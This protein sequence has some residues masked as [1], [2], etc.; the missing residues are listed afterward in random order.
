M[1]ESYYGV[2]NGGYW[3]WNRKWWVRV[4]E[5][6][7]KGNATNGG[8][9]MSKKVLTLLKKAFTQDYMWTMKKYFGDE[10]D[11]VLALIERLE[12]QIWVIF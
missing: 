7:T 11:N 2:N 12:A 4:S 6:P 9:R 8:W 3:T 10:Y 1:S 5:T